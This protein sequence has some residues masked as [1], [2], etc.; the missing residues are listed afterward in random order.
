[1]VG[2][3]SATK[4]DEATTAKADEAKAVKAVEGAALIDTGKTVAEAASTSLRTEDQPGSRSGEREVHTISLN[5]PPK[6]HGKRVMDAKVSST[7][8]M[9]APGAPEE[10]EVKGNLA[11]VRIETDPWAVLVPVSL[12]GPKGRRR[13]RTG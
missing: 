8:E 13:R 10:P 11:L 1:M 7:A 3:A 2:E 4:I 5:E 9:A 12:G 6:P